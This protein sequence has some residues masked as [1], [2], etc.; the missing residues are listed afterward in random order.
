[1]SRH[2]GTAAVGYVAGSVE[3]IEP[4]AINASS[5]RLRE[6]LTLCH[7]SVIDNSPGGFVATGADQH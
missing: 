6:T 5:D 7:I 4:T 3:A 2:V 1:V